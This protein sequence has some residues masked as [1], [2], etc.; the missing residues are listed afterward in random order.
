MSFDQRGQA[1]Y[2]VLGTDRP[3]QF[4]FQGGYQLPW[5][6][7]LGV[8]YFLASGVPQQQQ[9]TIFNVPVFYLGRNNMGR[10]PTYSQ[11]D[12][13]VS[14]N[15][16]LFGNTSA[17][18]ELNVLNLFDQ[19]TVTGYNNTPYRDAIPLTTAQF[20]NGFSAD[21]IAAATTSVRKDARF[22][23]PNG[24]QGARSIRVDFKFRF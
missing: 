10:T 17:I 14:Q 15:V 11:T 21:A 8:F 22:G 9:V 24:F 23:L 2:G 3:H 1:V 20:F 12:F 16:H 19:D 7:N 13:N 18:V 6:T 5:G 4:K